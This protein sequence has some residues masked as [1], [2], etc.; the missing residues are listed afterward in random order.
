MHFL[1]NLVTLNINSQVLTKEA[2]TVSSNEY[3]HIPDIHKST[4]K[5]YNNVDDK[6]KYS[7][8]HRS[9][10]DHNGDSLKNSSRRDVNIYYGI[11]D[12]ILFELS[13]SN[14]DEN[15]A[16]KQEKRNSSET[17]N[18]EMKYAKNYGTRPIP[19]PRLPYGNDST[20]IENLETLGSDK[21]DEDNT[22][23]LHIFVKNAKHI[24]HLDK[25]ENSNTTHLLLSN[26]IKN[27]LNGRIFKYTRQ[28]RYA[29]LNSMHSKPRKGKYIEYNENDDILGSR[30]VEEGLLPFYR[31]TKYFL[32]P[33]L[34]SMID[35][36]DE[37]QS[38]KVEG[39]SGELRTSTITTNG[40]EED[41][42]ASVS[43]KNRRT[44]ERYPF[45][46]LGKRDD[47]NKGSSN[48]SSSR[49][50][51][52]R[53]PSKNK[54]ETVQLFED[55][56]PV[57]NLR[58]IKDNIDNE[59]ENTYDLKSMDVS[60]EHEETIVKRD[61]TNG[62]LSEDDES[63]FQ[64]QTTIVIPDKTELTNDDKNTTFSDVK[65]IDTNLSDTYMYDDEEES[66]TPNPLDFLNITGADFNIT[67]S[68]N[69]SIADRDHEKLK[70]I[71]QISKILQI[72]EHQAI[73]GSNCTPGTGLNMGDIDLV[74]NN[75]KKFRGAAEVAVNR[76]NWLT[77]MW[78]YASTVMLDGGK[79][80]EYLLHS[81]LFSMIESNEMIF[82]AGNCY[83]GKQYKNYSLFCPFAYK[84]PEVNH[85]ILGKDLAVEYKYLK[86]SST[87]F[88]TP[89]QH[90][91]EMATKLERF[92]TGRN[93][94]LNSI[95]FYY[96]KLS[97]SIYQ[98]NAVA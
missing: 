45:L 8:H 93:I 57:L 76:A 92:E 38:L 53:K 94:F 50:I 11:S 29:K 22:R 42:Y 81:S 61:G 18:G 4:N 2:T 10:K 23:V 15:H 84:S 21:Q 63:R 47:R 54:K 89:K 71:K 17:K 86:P 56:R 72:V 85:H 64:S 37:S 55:R 78:K 41:Y 52:P 83:D 36:D 68:P 75:Y 7:Q 79:E 46:H 24:P 6:H 91:K 14:N 67:M 32:S 73:Q 49:L 13:P 51:K 43:S 40:V 77:R 90:A 98:Y 31:P 62:P 34:S 9:L 20:K 80:S 87:W 82:G 12:K 97:R 25:V 35:D 70:K 48:L 66:I 88:W 74:G 33:Q 69:S 58:S 30:M 44:T 3:Q 16:F 39:P 26:N 1:F 5:V 65:I 96:K 27:V 19:K 28:K 60:Y 95:W 59:N